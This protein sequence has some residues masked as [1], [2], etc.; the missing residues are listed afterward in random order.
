LTKSRLSNVL[1]AAEADLAWFD[2][3][4]MAIC[5]SPDLTLTN[6]ELSKTL[7][8]WFF[9]EESRSSIV[10]CLAVGLCASQAPDESIECQKNVF[11]G[12]VSIAL[13][14]VPGDNDLVSELFPIIESSVSRFSDKISKIACELG[15][16]DVIADVSA[17]FPGLFANCIGLLSTVWQQKEAIRDYLVSG[18]AIFYEKLEEG[19]I[20]EPSSIEKAKEI[21]DLATVSKPSRENEQLIRNYHVLEPLLLFGKTYCE[22]EFWIAEELLKLASNAAN[23]YD[24]G[25]GR[26][27]SMIFDRIL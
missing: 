27:V 18:D 11:S 12:I 22:W 21:L 19:T 10:L 13:K 8:N 25:N 7:A 17:V 23:L 9:D 3:I 14:C 24:F 26:I 16:F 1:A 2:F 20:K 5:R 4:R 15:L 6:Y